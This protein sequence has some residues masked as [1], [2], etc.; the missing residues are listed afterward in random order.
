M[1][2]MGL[3]KMKKSK[4]LI[5]LAEVILFIS[6]IVFNLI[7]KNNYMQKASIILVGVLLL[8]RFRIYKNNNYL[9][10]HVTKVVISCLMS[11]LITIYLLGLFMGFNR[12]VFAF[13]LNYIFNIIVLEFVVIVFEELI[14]YIICKNTNN[15]LPIILFTIILCILNIIIEINGYDLSDNEELFIFITKVVLPVISREC[16]CTYLTYRVGYTPSIIF[17]ATI[18]LYSYIFPIIPNLGNYVYAVVNTFLPYMIYFFASKLVDYNSKTKK[19]A[20]KA[21]RRVFYV[22]TLAM[23]VILVILVSGVFTHTII[24]VASNSMVPEYSRGDAVIY[25]KVSAKDIEVGEILAYKNDGIIITHRVLS[26]QKNGNSYLF[27]TK[28]DANETPDANLIKESQVL[29][30]VNLKIKYIGYPTLWFNEVIKGK[31]LN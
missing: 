15:K 14:R 25:E 26:K 22:P 23:L 17:K 7:Y 4:G 16:I 24:A 2:P 6:I 13:N 19:Y 27:K 8:L 31:E 29:G 21:V 3:I 18:V 30:K 10:P 12:T 28:G 11:F 9:N 5:Y 20:N 1:L